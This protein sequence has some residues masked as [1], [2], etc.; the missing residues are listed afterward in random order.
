VKPGLERISGLLDVLAHP[1]ESYPIIHVAGTNGKTSTSRMAGTL[2]S[3][4]GLTAG[5]FTSPHLDAIEGRFEVGGFVMSPEVFADVVS[6]LAPIVD[7]HEE[8]TGD[9]IT[10][11]ELTAAMAFSWFA[12]Q[13]VDVGVIEVGLGGRLDATNVATSDVAVVTTIGLEHTDYLGTTVPLIAAEKLAILERESVLVTG[14]LVPEAIVVAEQRARE[15]GAKW[16]RFGDDFGPAEAEQTRTGWRFHLDGIHGR[17][18]DLELR[19]HGRHQVA[20][21]ATAVAAV[22][23][24]FDR[25]LDEAAVREAAARA[26]SPGRMEAIRTEP[27]V[28]TDGAHNP[29]GVAALAAALDEEYRNLRWTVVF[30]AMSDKDVPAM[31]VHLRDAAA[32]IHTAAAHTP[33]AMPAEEMARVVADVIGVPATA[34]PSVAEAVRAAL[35][36]GGPVLITGS[37]YVVG[38][39]R[40]AL[41]VV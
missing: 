1:E 30:G 38:E 7:M 18:T 39:A 4:M 8:R 23:A 6:E 13:A 28:L 27:L 9:G 40:V 12:D 32:S 10:Y 29:D 25:D 15:Q 11:F 24:L 26:T 35:Q 34:H 36:G 33:R 2:V 21:F 17:Y 22:E 14:H 5:V 16:F 41:G 20:N 3:A 31:L 37:I 19:L